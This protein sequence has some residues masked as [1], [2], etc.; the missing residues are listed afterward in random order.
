[1]G[2]TQASASLIL[3]DN[4]KTLKPSVYRRLEVLIN[5]FHHIGKT[6]IRESIESSPHEGALVNRPIQQNLVVMNKV[7]HSHHLLYT[8]PL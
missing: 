4:L 2:S 8:N 5:V 3:E 1:M 6:L 7:F